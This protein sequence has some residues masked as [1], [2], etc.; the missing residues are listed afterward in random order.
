MIYILSWLKISNLSWIWWKNVSLNCLHRKI[1]VF[2]RKLFSPS[3]LYYFIFYRMLK[4]I[5]SKTFLQIILLV[6]C[7]TGIPAER[8]EK[9]MK[10]FWTKFEYSLE[11]LKSVKPFSTIQRQ[12]LKAALKLLKNYF[13]VHFS[14]WRQVMTFIS[15]EHIGRRGKWTTGAGEP[16][17]YSLSYW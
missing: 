1:N 7:H 14:H 9:L 4:F 3:D 16:G 8:D 13:F 17:F 6:R 2:L 5:Q 11:A 12:W 15:P 10:W